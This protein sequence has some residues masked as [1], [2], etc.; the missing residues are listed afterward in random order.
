MRYA[1]GIIF[2]AIIPGI[3]FLGAAAIKIA[4]IGADA[5]TLAALWDLYVIWFLISVISVISLPIIMYFAKRDFFKEFLFYEAGGLCFFSPFWL[6]FATEISGESWTYLLLHG[7]T[8]GL[9]GP[10]PSNTIVGIDISNTILV[11]FL[12]LSIIFGVV[13]LHP[14]FLAKHIGPRELP[15]LTALKKSTAGSEDELTETDMP[16]VIPPTTTVD[17]VASLREVL[18]ELGTSDPIINLILNSGIG[19]TTEFVATSPDQLANITGIDRRA[20]ENLLIS[21]QKKL[22]FSDI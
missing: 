8:S 1:H 16:G 20:A 18:I 21:V 2:G 10:G 6:F 11:P 22:W 14:S 13:I 12:I 19:T 15:E 5:P 17:S 9:V 7:I 3:I 4:G